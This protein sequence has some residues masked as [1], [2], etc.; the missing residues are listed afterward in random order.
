[1]LARVAPG[2]VVVHKDWSP[3]RIG[4]AIRSKLPGQG[5]GMDAIQAAMLAKPQAPA[6][7]P[8]PVPVTDQ[9]ERLANF[10]S[11]SLKFPQR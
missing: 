9:V 11:G 3:A 2:I 7:E 5:E 4:G 6:P 10:L 8:V 1:M